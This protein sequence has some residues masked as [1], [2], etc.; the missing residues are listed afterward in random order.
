[1]LFSH[2]NDNSL[3]HNSVRSILKDNQGGMWIGTFY[4]GLNY[5]HPMAP[6]FETLT[7]SAY[8]NSI[9]DNTVSCIVEDPHTGNLWI[10]TNDGGLNEYDRKKTIFLFIVPIAIMPMPYNQTISNVC[11]RMEKVFILEAMAED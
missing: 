3:G 8:K 9:S 1:M 4:G 5:Y 11:F 6:A 2:E 10:G 7:Y